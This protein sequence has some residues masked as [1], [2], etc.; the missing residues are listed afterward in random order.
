MTRDEMIEAMCAAVTGDRW[1]IESV[2]FPRWAGDWKRRMLLSLDAIEPAIRANERERCAKAIGNK[3]F[4]WCSEQPCS[5][6]VA[7]AVLDQVVDY[8]RRG[9]P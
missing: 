6:N 5:E 1:P 3:V 9:A 7:R 2:A 4:G 8:V